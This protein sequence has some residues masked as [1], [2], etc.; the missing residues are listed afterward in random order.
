MKIMIDPEKTILLLYGTKHCKCRGEHSTDY[1]RLHSN[2]NRQ[3]ILTSAELWIAF[4]SYRRKLRA[5]HYSHGKH[6]LLLRLF[7]L[8]NFKSGILYHIRF[9]F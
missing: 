8:I 4:S 7:L 2:N 6:L 5:H 1:R 9:R 3:F